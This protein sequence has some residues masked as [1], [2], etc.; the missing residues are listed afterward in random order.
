M[1]HMVESKTYFATRI[2]PVR[3]RLQLPHAI[4]FPFKEAMSLS[5]L[6]SVRR[7][8]PTWMLK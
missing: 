1:Y 3:E 7:W 4:I 5:K 6:A 2:L 8:K